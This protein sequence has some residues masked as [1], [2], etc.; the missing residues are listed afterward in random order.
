[1]RACTRAASGWKLFTKE[2]VIYAEDIRRQSRYI[3][4]DTLRFLFARAYVFP[5]EARR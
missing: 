1:M 4:Y 2:G 5:L 3:L